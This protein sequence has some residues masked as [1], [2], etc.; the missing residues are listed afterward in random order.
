MKIACDVLSNCIFDYKIL[1]MKKS[2]LLLLLSTFSFLQ[3]QETPNIIIMIGDGM[4]LTQITAGMYS[5]NNTIALEDFEFIGLSKTHALGQLVT[6]SAAS[7]TAMACGIKTY[8]GVIGI[9]KNNAHQPSILELSQKK[10]YSTGLVVTSSVVHAT[11]ASFYAKVPSRKLYEDIALQ[12]S[13]HS[14]DLIIGGG[15]DFFNKREDKRDLIKEMN[16]YEFVTDL[17]ELQITTSDKIG[18]L[19][20]KKEPP[21]KLEGRSPALDE[22]VATSLEK[23]DARKKPFFLLVEG[24][25]IDWGGH[26]NEMDYMVS[27]FK[28]FDKTIEKV[29]DF[30]KKDGNTL[31]IVT[32][33]H[34]TGGL[35]LKGGNLE[36]ATVKGDFSTEGH[37]AAMVPVFSYGPF[38]KLFAGIYENTA[39]FEKMKQALNAEQ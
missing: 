30:A 18:F 33:D 27:E 23:L 26:A 14:L 15:L 21:K 34:E 8:N 32:A 16:Q 39:I 36:K 13:Q 22:L 31:V 24:S 35:T 25:Q 20:Y 9:D 5:N 11:P 7:G 17:K 38:S 29:L 28:E 19:T 6:D 4:G 3:S 37:S 12:L 2:F 10:G 1:L